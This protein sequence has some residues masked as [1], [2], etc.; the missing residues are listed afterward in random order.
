MNNATYRPEVTLTEYTRRSDAELRVLTLSTVDITLDKLLLPL[1]RALRDQGFVS[2]CA[3]ADGAHAELLRQMGFVVHPISFK[4]R[5]LSTSHITSFFQLY[6]CFG[7]AR[8][9]SFTCILRSHRS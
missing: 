2:E 6:R 4:R 9:R 8:T 7:S 5:L 3:S 1:I